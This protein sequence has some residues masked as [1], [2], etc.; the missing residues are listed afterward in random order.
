MVGMII[1]DWTGNTFATT[2]NSVGRENISAWPKRTIY[3]SYHVPEGLCRTCFNCNCPGHFAKDCRVM[4]RNVNPVNV[5]NPAP[6]RRACYEIKENDRSQTGIHGNQGNQ[7]RGRAFMLGVEEAR[8]DPNIVTGG[9]E[10]SE[11][12]YDVIIDELLSKSK[13]E[14]IC[15][16]KV[17]RIPLLDGKV[18]R[19]L[20][21]RTDEKSKLL[22]V[23]RLA[24]IRK[25]NCS[26]RDFPKL[27]PIQSHP[28]IWPSS[29]LE[30]LSGQ[31]KELQD[32]CFIRP[33]SSPWGGTFFPK[34]DLR[35]GYH[36][37]RVHE[38]DILKTAFRT[39]TDISSSQPYLD[40][41]VIVFID[42]ILI[43]SKTREKHVEHLSFLG[44][45]INGNGIHVDRSKI[46]AVKNW[47]AFRTP[48]EVRSFLGLAGYY[49]RCDVRTPDNVI[50]PISLKYSVHPGD[51]KMYYDLRDRY[52]WP[53]MK[54]D[55]AVYVSKCLACLKVKA[56]HQRPSG[57]LQQPEIPQWK[58]ESDEVIEDTSVQYTIPIP[59]PSLSI[60][61]MVTLA[62]QDRWSQ[63]KHIELVNI[64]CVTSAGMLTRSMA[65]DLG[66]TSAHECL[67]EEEPK[68]SCI[69][70]K[71]IIGSKWVFR[72]KRDE[73][74]IVIK[75]KA[76]LVA[77]G[78]NQQEGIDYDETFA[79]VAR[80]EAIRIFLAF[81]THM[82]FIV[83]QMVVKSSFLNGKL[84]EVYVKQ[85]PGFE[86]GEFSNH[87]YKLDKDLYGLKQAPR[88]WYET[89]LTYLTKH[90]FVRGFDLKG[91]SDSD[92]AGC[93]MD[94]KST[95][96]KAEYVAAVRCC[97][98]II[99][100][101]SQLTDY[102]II[103]EKTQ[104]FDNTSA[105]YQFK[106]SILHFKNKAYDRDYHII[107]DHISKR[108]IELTI[109]IPT[110]YQ[111]A[112]IFT[113]PWMSQLSK[114]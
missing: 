63:D 20:G 75:N 38:D 89:L 48:T 78:Y 74:G 82:N 101:K 67:S 33:S 90:K 16:E 105:N 30:E 87:V 72:N 28:N 113:S 99:W 37:L 111:L 14:I 5:R 85:P 76:R 60:P 109:F 47:K 88:A 86:S 26:S 96:T 11:L 66:A 64:H 49:R 84:K 45:V 4:P 55:I 95:S 81:A 27:V 22:R 13:A 106:Q 53:G 40:K 31:L 80:L 12:V 44:H 2:A 46:E 56:E 23:L 17:A 103:Y 69:S 25:K 34:I 93:N 3:N 57:L 61:S 50:K 107:K 43:Y 9:I 51:D 7:A 77:Q 100:M 19:E 39:D 112:D 42:D 108:D 32:K 97:A 94:R 18:L 52:W 91:Y 35:S 8:Q 92:Y 110:Q 59:N 41:Y 71:T 114:D 79:P 29:E 62:P 98:N 15:H 65:K 102:D 73:T 104:F 1:R 36:Q 24:L 70:C 68:K 6:A 54:K 58:W 21:E 83:Y 10:T